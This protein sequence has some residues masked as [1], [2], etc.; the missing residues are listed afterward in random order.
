MCVHPVPRMLQKTSR[1]LGVLL[2]GFEPRFSSVLDT[3]V[4]GQIVRQNQWCLL[5]VCRKPLLAGPVC[6]VSMELQ[7][8]C[9]LHQP[10]TIRK[11][12]FTAQSSP[13][14]HGFPQPIRV[15]H[16]IPF[17]I[18]ASVCTPTHTLWRN[19]ERKRRCHEEVSVEVECGCCLSSS[20]STGSSSIGSSVDLWTHMCCIQFE[21]L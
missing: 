11:S 8:W 19:R 9:L 16:T 17:G 5:Q 21:R 6:L 18:C 14:P 3:K 7:T 4:W 13:A 20:Y 1:L 15:I 12:V 10:W 2:M